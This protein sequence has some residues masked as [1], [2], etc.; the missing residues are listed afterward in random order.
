M[1]L[2][3]LDDASDYMDVKKW[4]Q[5]EEMLDKYSVKPL[6]GIIPHNEDKSLTDKWQQNE[7]FWEKALEWKEKGWRIAL[8]GYNHVYSTKSGGMNPVNKKSEFAGNAI[9]VQR[10]KIRDGFAVLCQK[11]LKPDVFFAP[12]HTFDENTLK[13]LEIETDIRIISD[14]VANDVYFSDGFF[15]IPQ[16]TGTPR[17]L[18]MKLVTICIHPN[19]MDERSIAG[20]E[21][22]I[23]K[24]RSRI[25]N[26]YDVQM[27]KRRLDLLDRLLKKIYFL[28]RA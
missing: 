7:L 18:P 1:Y 21:R 10:Q 2:F 28:K 24:N 9:E 5:I 11:G 12:S 17:K 4:N 22:F 27:Q 13:A 14:T 26:A 19:T 15:F 3:R 25:I 6:V 8:H 23:I 16:Q 20:L